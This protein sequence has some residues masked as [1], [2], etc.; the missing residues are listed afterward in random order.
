MDIECTLSHGL[1]VCDGVCVMLCG[2]VVC[3][4]MLCDDVVWWMLWHDVVCGVVWGGMIDLKLFGGFDFRQMDRWT[5]GRTLGVVESLSRLKN[6]KTRQKVLKVAIN[7]AK[8][9]KLKKIDCL[10]QSIV[11]L[12]RLLFSVDC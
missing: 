12:S 6:E 7:R 8:V 4:V 11:D 3:V 10:S 2:D 1:C 5:N 9:E